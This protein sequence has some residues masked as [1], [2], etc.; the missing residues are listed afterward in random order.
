MIAMQ[1]EI[2]AI[3]IEDSEF[4]EIVLTYSWW[5][6]AVEP[7]QGW[8]VRMTGRGTSKFGEITDSGGISYESL[9]WR[10]GRDTLRLHPD[11]PA[12]QMV[13]IVEKHF[14]CCAKIHLMAESGDK[15]CLN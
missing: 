6:N 1:T 4:G 5:Y 13:S 7:N 3:T 11:I 2:N 8:H 12:Q 14:E 9:L 10:Y 15:C